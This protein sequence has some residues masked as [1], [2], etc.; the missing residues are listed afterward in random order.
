MKKYFLFLGLLIVVSCKRAEAP[1]AGFDMCFE[2]PQPINDSDLSKIPKKFRGVFMSKDSF[3][4]RIEEKEILSESYLKFRIYKTDLD[5]IK[6]FFSYPNSNF[7][8]S[9]KII[10]GDSLEI[11]K[12]DIDTFF[13]FSDT[14]KAKRID[15]RLV[16]N[17]K[18]SIYWKIKVISLEKNIFKIKYIYS[19]EDLNRVDSL[20]KVKSTMIDSSLFV[21]KP[22]R[23]EFKR[24]INL[25]KLGEEQNYK[26]IK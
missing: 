7:K 14:Q 4:I 2:N 16:L 15:G 19:E 6:E 22:S 24:I 23:N 12:K 1:Y 25:N 26:K 5:S 18:D 13:V 11:I 21:L 17:Y 3:F 20:T 8:L 9:T 10:K